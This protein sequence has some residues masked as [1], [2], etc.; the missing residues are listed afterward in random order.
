[1]HA[2]AEHKDSHEVETAKLRERLTGLQRS[3]ERLEEK[4][5]DQYRR[6]SGGAQGRRRSKSP[7]IV[8]RVARGLLQQA[9][10]HA[11]HRS[12]STSASSISRPA[13]VE[14]TA[15]FASAASRDLSQLPASPSPSPALLQS[16]SE[17]RPNGSALSAAAA[18]AGATLP[19]PSSSLSAYSSAAAHVQTFKD[20]LSSTHHFP[21]RKLASIQSRLNLL[22]P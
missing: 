18:S 17:R 8:Q 12:Q 16:T 9:Q 10:Q 20:S 11:A 14:P 19:R 6:S 5:M 3:K 21:D 1:M 22:G 4:I 7:G 2:C 13:S 15:A